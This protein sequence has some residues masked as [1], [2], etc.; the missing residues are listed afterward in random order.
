MR[1]S[2][3][4]MEQFESR[5]LLSAGAVD[6]SYFPAFE[7]W[8]MPVAFSSQI[9]PQLDGK[10]MHYAYIGPND[11]STQLWR[12]NPNGTLDKTFGDKGVIN[13]GAAEVNEFEVGS[14]GKI[15]A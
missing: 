6:P 14:N 10:M 7:N 4:C 5:T 12:T 8:R 3:V 1:A 11:Q 2:C 13:L 15:V 9:Q